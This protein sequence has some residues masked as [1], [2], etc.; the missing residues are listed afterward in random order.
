[1]DSASRQGDD[2]IM[3]NDEIDELLS[4]TLGNFWLG[5]QATSSDEDH[6]GLVRQSGQW[7]ELQVLEPNSHSAFMNDDPITHPEYIQAQT[8][9][10]LALLLDTEWT[11]QLIVLGPKASTTNFRASTLIFPVPLEELESAE[12]YS[13][14]ANFPG[15]GRWAG[16]QAASPT[17]QKHDDGRL[18][19][20]STSVSSDVE[21][22]AILPANRTLKIGTT[23][24]VSGPEDRV[25]IYAPVS[26]VCESQTPSQTW[27]LLQPLIA[28]QD[29]L[30]IA[31]NGFVVADSEASRVSCTLGIL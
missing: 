9:H 19:G 16:M 21:Y 17:W 11:S 2:V 14:Q 26:L 28:I 18:R 25:T 4:G 8:P 3:A 20:F 1:M 29:M 23:W 10:G 31:F 27:H 15:I 12:V 24:T 6:P 5:A 22:A 13:L 7:L 30:N